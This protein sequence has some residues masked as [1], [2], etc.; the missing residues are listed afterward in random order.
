[1][2]EV[3]SLPDAVRRISADSGG[4]LE[5]WIVLDAER[6]QLAV[7]AAEADPDPAAV[8]LHKGIQEVAAS[9]A[10]AP[11]RTPIRCI[12]CSRLLK[13]SAY[14][15]VVAAPPGPVIGHG[16]V[17]AVCERCGTTTAKVRSRAVIALRRL[18][19]NAQRVLAD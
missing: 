2:H 17:L 3:V 15:V 18:W 7:Q 14:A 1:M 19:P 4:E 6:A 5:L 13:K 10:S 16:V 8:R 11:R 9:V 12:S